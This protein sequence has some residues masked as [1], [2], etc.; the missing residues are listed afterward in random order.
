MATSVQTLVL[1]MWGPSYI[2]VILVM[3][4][5]K[6]ETGRR[7]SVAHWLGSL[8]CMKKFMDR[9]SLPSK[10]EKAPEGLEPM[11][12]DLHTIHYKYMHTPKHTKTHAHKIKREIL[13]GIDIYNVLKGD[14]NS[15]NMCKIWFEINYYVTGSRI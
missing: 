15:Y 7:L 10:R 9:E 14:Q 3:E 1:Q 8:T 2:P 4:G 5:W 11:S 13:E 6:R 12:S